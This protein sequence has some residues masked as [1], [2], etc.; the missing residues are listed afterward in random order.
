MLLGW[1]VLPV[2]W[3][4][5]L[6]VAPL[7]MWG[8]LKLHPGW[9]LAAAVVLLLVQFNALRHRVPLYRS[10]GAVI[11][12]LAGEIDARQIPVL[13]DIGCGDGHVLAALARRF[14]ERRFVGFETAPLLFLLARWRCRALPNCEVRWRDFWKA[15][16]GEFGAVFAFLSPEP[17]LRVWRKSQRD[18]GPE[19]ALYSLAFEVP[20]IEAERL[21]GAGRFDLFRYPRLVAKPGDG[22]EVESGP[23]SGPVS[24]PVSGSIP[25]AGA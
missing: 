4:G 7:L 11:E 19:G 1:R 9:F 8:G 10:G 17:M 16:W 18:L 5:V 3:R 21:I 24:G 13:A 20:G 15:D 25:G 14:P 12:A 23:E 2:W 22:H 6:L